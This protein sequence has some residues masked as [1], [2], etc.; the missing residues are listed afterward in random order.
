MDMI[1]FDSAGIAFPSSGW[2]SIGRQWERFVL[3][4]FFSLIF[5]LVSCASAPVIYQSEEYIIYQVQEGDTPAAM[6]EKF[7]GGS[8]RSWVIEDANEPISFQENQMIT[9]P[10]LQE[11]RAGL[12]PDGY[13][14]VP[15]L[16]YHHFGNDCHSPL[17]I[18][19]P[20]FE[21]Q[22][23][24]LKDNGYRVISLAQFYDFL[25]YRQGIPKRSVIITIDDGYRSVYDIAFPILKQYGFPATLFIYTDF[26]GK[27]K[28]AANWKQLR[29]MKAAGIEIGSH[30]LSHCDLNQKRSGEDTPGFETRIEEE[31]RLSKQIL[32]A[33]LTQDTLFF[34][35]PYSS[36]NQKVLSLCEQTGYKLSLTVKRGGNPFFSDPFLLKRN[37]VLKKDMESFAH[38]LKTL[39]PVSLR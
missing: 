2:T 14:V 1:F 13:Q 36:Y 27:S 12:T 21:Q 19:A 20:V 10:L 26:I 37:Q 4:V 9:I 24:Y 38:I 7:L 22:M 3:P 35:F 25:R 34:A 5:T 31:L 30:T 15:I 33:K 8:E 17:C 11:N 28:N 39:Y 6:A 16:C 18:P 32:D 23:Q 29:E